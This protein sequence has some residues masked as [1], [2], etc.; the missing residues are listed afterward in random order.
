MNRASKSRTIAPSSRHF[1]MTRFRTARIT[2][3]LL[4]AVAGI[5]PGTTLHAGNVIYVDI[6][7][8]GPMHDGSSW[9]NAF[10]DLQE[11][12]DVADAGDDIL[13]ADGT[14]VPRA[15]GLSD[16]RDATFQ[17]VSGV[18]VRGGYAGCFALDPNDNNPALYETILSGDLD[19]DDGP[20]FTGYDDNTY[21]VVT[22]IDV[23]SATA[24]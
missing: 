21:H 5:V 14:Y 23:N 4:G 2:P 22:A 16:P 17:L 9:C 1:A 24:L 11:A 10:T 18:V 12:L 19:G 8:T 13:V 20:D 3:A 7:A 6:N 15:T